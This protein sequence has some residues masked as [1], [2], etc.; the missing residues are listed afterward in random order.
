MKK[1]IIVVMAAVI[2][3]I[4]AGAMAIG[5]GSGMGICRGQMWGN[6]SAEGDQKFAQFQKET[7]PLRQKILQLKS[8]LISLKAQSPTD[9]ESV[10]E[11][12]KEMVDLRTEIQKKAS[13]SGLSIAGQCDCGRGMGMGMKRMGRMTM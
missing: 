4:A 9:W 5:P 12:E 3:T 8:D 6:L 2:F 10:A 11:K 1:T 7:L 13:E